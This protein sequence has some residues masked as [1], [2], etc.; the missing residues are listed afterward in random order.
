MDIACSSI[1]WGPLRRG[2]EGPYA[3]LAGLERI[4]DEIRAAGYDHAVASVSG[5]APGGRAGGGAAEEGPLATPEG[6]LDLLARHGLRPAPGSIGGFA[7]SDPAMLEANVEGARRA[8]R[9]TRGL[10]LDAVYLMP[11]V[12]PPRWETPGHYPEGNRPDRPSPAHVAATCEALNRMGEACRAE[13]VWL[14]PHNH[15]GMYWETA[16]EYEEVVAGTDP[17]LVGLGPDVGHMVWG[18][19][20]PVSW[21]RRHMERVKSI[22]I[23]D[24]DGAVLE[25]ARR[26]G[27]SYRGA[28]DA[29]IWTEIGSGA[30]DWPALFARW[31]DAG[32]GGAVVVESDRTRLPTP[33]ESV[34]RSRAY[35]RETIGV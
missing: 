32:Y 8:A 11:E 25:R 31:R 5:R 19:I 16:D 34:A 35:L 14:C 21:F 7:L 4:L 27:L 3:G 17:A 15:A 26:E 20:D 6:Q 1:T 13:G 29:G 23:K 18:G 28:S 24:V 30:V 22:H 2:G 10:G 33:A 9:Y 12:A